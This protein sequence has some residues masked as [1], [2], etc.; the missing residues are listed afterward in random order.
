MLWWGDVWTKLSHNCIQIY[1]PHTSPCDD[2]NLPRFI[3]C[4]YLVL[5]HVLP[6]DPQLPRFIHC[7]YLVLLHVLPDDPQLPRFIHCLYLCH[8]HIIILLTSTI[9]LEMFYLA[10]LLNCIIVQPIYYQSNFLSISWDFDKVLTTYPWDFDMMFFANVFLCNS[11][12]INM[13]L[14]VE[15]K[16]ILWQS[17][18]WGRRGFWELFMRSIRLPCVHAIL[19]FKGL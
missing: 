6:D 15:I 9:M 13:I 3:H 11:N 2:P 19:M 14:R 10:D 12:I 16:R 5:L 18:E 4:L 17:N 1:W 8:L 7:L